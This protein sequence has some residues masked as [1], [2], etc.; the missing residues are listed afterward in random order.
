VLKKKLVIAAA[1][2]AMGLLGG[3]LAHADPAPAPT[4]VGDGPDPN[5]PKC[6]GYGGDDGTVFQYTPCGWR[7]GDQRGWYQAP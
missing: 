6:A 4:P 7:Y 5:G 3:G 2:A 1:C